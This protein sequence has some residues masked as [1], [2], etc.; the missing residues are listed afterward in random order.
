M[1]AT[2]APGKFVAQDH[3]QKEDAMTNAIRTIEKAITDRSIGDELLIEKFTDDSTR[4]VGR[5][6]FREHAHVIERNEREQELL[7]AYTSDDDD[8]EHDAEVAAGVA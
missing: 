5:G 8:S 1:R 7:D 4:T 6:D 2:G 3:L